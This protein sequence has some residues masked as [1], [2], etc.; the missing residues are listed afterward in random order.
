[1]LSNII[2]VENLLFQA[3]KLK[4]KNFKPGFDKMDAKAAALWLEINGKRFCKDILTMN[5]EPMPAVAFASAKR[6]GGYRKLAKLTALD[7]V[8]HYAVLDALTPLCEELFSEFSYA[9][10]PGRGLSQAV[11][12]Y[13]ELGS[14][15][16]YAAKLDP[17]GC[18]DNISHDRLKAKLLT[19]TNDSALCSFIMCLIKAPVLFDG[20]SERP[21]KGLVQGAPLSP[22][23]CNIY[24]DSMDKFLENIGVPFVRYADDIAMF[25]DIPEELNRRYQSASDFML[26]ELLLERHEKKSG[27]DSSI[28]LSFLGCKFKRSRYGLIAVE[29][30]ES[31]QSVYAVWHETRPRDGHGRRDI[32]NDGI[33]R[34]K[35][36]SLEFESDE[37]KCNIPVAAV[38]NINVYSN[39]IFDSGTL[40]RSLQNGIHIN[41]FNKTNRLIG[42]FIPNTKLRS[43]ITTHSQ[44]AAYYSNEE[45]LSIAAEF[46]KA[47]LHHSVLNIKYYSGQN[48]KECY[49]SALNRIKECMS[50][51]DELNDYQKLLL[52]EARAREAYYACFDSF[53]ISEDFKFLKRTRRP[54]KNPVNAALSFG[55]TVLYNMTATAVNKSSLDIRIGYLHATN[56][57]PESLNLDIA[58]IFKPLLVDRTV[59]SLFNRKM[60]RNEHFDR[61]DNGAF[62]LN[63]FGLSVFLKAFYDKVDSHIKINGIMMT[64]GHIIENEI[65]K[66]VRKFRQNEPY[67]AFKQLK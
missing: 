24:L 13:C 65:V 30:G 56:N 48:H 6:G 15:Y 5:Y 28:N 8:L 55:N 33:L 35:D 12:R 66:L 27:L 14:K 60:L 23:L 67:A 31:Q 9:Y 2:T 44:L 11:S 61:S 43:P 21:L 49:D 32:L 45:R 62:Y 47:S 36:F 41:V 51:I 39:V 63:E 17:K 37:S 58:E 4:K 29:K 52:T 19:I 25:G 50:C 54:P 1:M 18:F 16:R 3:D 20:E 10:R 64:Y 22:L 59:F 40:E 26:N 46:V 42:R 38:D 53:L 57:R 34:Q 7:A